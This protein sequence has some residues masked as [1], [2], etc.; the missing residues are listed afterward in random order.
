MVRT[1]RVWSDSA[2]SMVTLL[3]A[4]ECMPVTAQGSLLGTEYGSSKLNDLSLLT[5]TGATRLRKYTP[6]SCRVERISGSL[7][8]SMA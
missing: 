6:S 3:V 8:T 2:S 1:R 5:S 4:V 7:V